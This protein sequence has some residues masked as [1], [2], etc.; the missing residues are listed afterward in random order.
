MRSR[1]G[2]NATLSF[3]LSLTLTRPHNNEEEE[4]KHDG[5]HR[6]RRLVLFL[7]VGRE[8]VEASALRWEKNEKMKNTRVV[9]AQSNLP[10][11]HPRPGAS[12]PRNRR[13]VVVARPAG[14]AAATGR[15]A[16]GC[17]GRRAHRAARV[18]EEND[19]E[20]SV[21]LS[22]LPPLSLTVATGTLPRLWMLAWNLLDLAFCTRLETA[23]G[24]GV[25]CGLGRAAERAGDSVRDEG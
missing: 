4:A 12:R 5:A 9:A 7:W 24:L 16:S 25:C 15:G 6:G 11:P 10:S 23:C 2:Q 18:R 14:G 8:E 21:S 20:I 13:S 3:L 1:G 22:L 17:E 19:K